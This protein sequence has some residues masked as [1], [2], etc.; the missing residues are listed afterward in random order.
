[1]VPIRRFQKY[2]GFVF[3]MILGFL[4]RTTPSLAQTDPLF[5]AM[6][7]PTAPF[8]IIG[9]I[10]YVGASDISAFLITT[11]EGYILLDSGLPE[12][13]P[14]I[15]Q[16]MKTLGF[17]MS[18]IKI[19][20]SHHSH[21]DHAGGLARLKDI[22]GASLMASEAD[23]ILLENGGKNDFH[24]GDRYAFPPVK[25]DRIL[26]DQD[27]VIIGNTILTAYLTPGHTKGCISVTMKVQEG[28]STLDV[29]FMGSISIPGYTLVNNRNYPNICADYEYSFQRLKTLPCDVFLSFHGYCFSLK[30]KKFALD[31]QPEKNPFIDPLGYI[32]A[33][34]SS[35][36][37]YRNQR[38]KE[39][40]SRSTSNMDQPPSP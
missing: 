23:S 29:V 26:H 27:Q 32:N 9:N 5:R 15:E 8:R 33:I 6:N 4:G 35:E 1:M 28:D 22:T 12:T 11:S 30:E 24:F 19:L 40:E 16:N 7:Q 38:N 18:D 36:Q 10:Y 14:Q 13:V 39:Q 2:V 3:M 34:Q 37:A 20:I 17:S 21:I 31:A 25:V